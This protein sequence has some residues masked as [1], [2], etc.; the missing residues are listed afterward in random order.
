MLGGVAAL[1]F[2]EPRGDQRRE[3]ERERERERKRE[4]ERDGAPGAPLSR[5]L[6]AGGRGRGRGGSKTGGI[7]G[8]RE[9]VFVCVRESVCER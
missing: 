6:W 5:C 1:P 8:E 9:G 4:R 2:P 3:R 7:L